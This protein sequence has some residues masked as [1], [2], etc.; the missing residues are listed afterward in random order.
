M[1][2]KLFESCRPVKGYLRSAFY[3]LQKEDFFFIP[4]A[5]YDFVA[6]FNNRSKKDII[7]AFEQDNNLE[8]LEEYLDFL[9]EKQVFFWCEEKDLPLFPAMDLTWKYPAHITNTIIELEST[10]PIHQIILCIASLNC[11]TLQLRA[12][13][14]T[15]ILSFVKE[16]S[17]SNIQHIEIFLKYDSS[18]SQE[19]IQEA[20]QEP[21]IKLFIVYYAPFNKILE[22]GYRL[23]AYQKHCPFDDGKHIDNFKVNISLF[24]E[25]QKHNTYFN[26][27]LYV[28]NTG[29][30]KNSPICKETFG[31]LQTNDEIKEIIKQ[32]NFQKYWHIS[33]DKIDVC[34][35][36]EFRYMCIDD[37]KPQQRDDKSWYNDKECNY[38]PYICKWQG[39]EGYLNLEHAGITCNHKY[40]TIDEQKLYKV[41]QQLWDE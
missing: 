11:T 26:R 21:R 18:I 31:I 7:E 9:T 17:E 3:D 20:L 27:K 41:N 5:V 1:Y 36:C 14:L 13:D 10:T 24:T 8:L 33:K 4:N 28:G 35:N 6:K 29:E 22:T 40:F 12:K 23:V 39:E 30:I 19:M 38:N 32:E 16:I 37:R 25:S 2:F 15:T 34:K